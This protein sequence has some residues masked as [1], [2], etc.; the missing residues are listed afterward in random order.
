MNDA[1]GGNADDSNFLGVS[2]KSI[3]ANDLTEKEVEEEA[4]VGLSGYKRIF[5]FLA[6][7]C[8]LSIAVII[9]GFAE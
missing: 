6:I 5:G 2:P 4:F 3:I 7:L 1:T 9:A 8:I